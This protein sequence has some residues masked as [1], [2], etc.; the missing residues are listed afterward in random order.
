[1]SNNRVTGR[2]LFA[3]GICLW[4]SGASASPQLELTANGVTDTL[5]LS[6]D[7]PIALQASLDPGDRAGHA[8][9]WWIHADTPFGRFSWVYPD[10]WVVGDRRTVS[11]PLIE[12][13]PYTLSTGAL[14]EGTYTI[15]FAV[16]DNA[17]GIRD[18]HWST[19]LQLRVGGAAQSSNEEVELCRF[20][21]TE[22]Q[23]QENPTVTVTN[24]TAEPLDL[25]VEVI[26]ATGGT[27]VRLSQGS[28]PAGDT[29]NY[30][31][32]YIAEQSGVDAPFTARFTTQPGDGVE[33]V[34]CS[35][36]LIAHRIPSCGDLMAPFTTEP[37]EPDAYF[38]I[39]PIGGIN[40]GGH[41]FATGHTYLML[42]D[43]W[44]PREVYAPADV[45]VTE[46][47]RGTSFDDGS[48]DHSIQFYPCAELHG[49]FNH[50]TELAPA[51]TDHLAPFG[52]CVTSPYAEICSQQS[53]I[54]IA[55]GTLIGYAGG[56]ATGSA[57]LDFGLR[58]YRADPI[59]YANP[60][61]L[62]NWRELYVAC[63]YDY[64]EEG[65]AREQLQ[66]RLAVASHGEPLCGS[67]AY[68]RPGTAQGRWFLA[69]SS[70]AYEPEHIALMPANTDPDTIGVLS[71]G[72]ADIGTDGYYFDYEY[73]GRINLSFDQVTA[74]GH[75]YCYDQLRSRTP[76]VAS[77]NAEALPGI[78]FLRMDDA[79]H[80]TLE[81]AT[82]A[83][84]CPADPD[85]LVFTSA[86]VA[87]E[88]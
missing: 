86:A 28:T 22:A 1:M 43:R 76:T 39:N 51:L 12:V 73:T 19:T 21:Y 37:L 75:T 61:R 41:T 68:D 11:A 59:L 69:G 48:V 58:D 32:A 25:A 9:D 38:Q 56:P 4:A 26:P 23:L 6:P 44:S 87:F 35:S 42:T 71:I 40:P 64:Y 84:A 18:A 65:S 81:R 63:P 66:D 78:L 17:D 27:T 13:P 8:A 15:H 80:L 55:A 57:A 50:V 29:M 60:D 33:A 5:D 82:G 46:V 72:N 79:E 31:V 83:A 24:P 74:D 14:P 47:S 20:L 2:P 7:T 53:D 10:G 45:T 70:G 67:V 54:R 30:S 85:S 52:D 49:F 16:D 62:E 3:L 77:G 34:D 36:N 88:R